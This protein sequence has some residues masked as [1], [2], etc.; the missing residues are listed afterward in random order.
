MITART[1]LQNAFNLE[2]F[3]FDQ[4]LHD[5]DRAVLTVRLE[6]GGSGGGNGLVHV[7][8]L[9]DET[10][11]VLSGR[12]KVVISGYARLVDAGSSVTVP[13]GAPHFFANAHDG[14]T[15]MT[16]A[17]TPAQQQLRFFANFA[18]LT[19]NRPGWFSAAGAPRL[20]LIALVFNAYRD[21]MYLAGPPIWMQKAL[22]AILAL[23]AQWRGYRLQVAP[24]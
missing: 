23:L 16:V 3:H 22:F 21:H 13:R 5:P 20:L 12:L 9:A 8:P 11:T 1:T 18:L 15:E 17:F 2:T 14:P 7:H 19:E 4:P 24:A 10:F 6:K